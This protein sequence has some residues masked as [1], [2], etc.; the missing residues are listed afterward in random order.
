MPL[1][2]K[3]LMLVKDNVKMTQNGINFLRTAA[4]ISTEPQIKNLC[5]QMAQEHERDIGLL[6]KHVTNQAVQ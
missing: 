2:S 6:V 1:T 5:S 3:E 4:E